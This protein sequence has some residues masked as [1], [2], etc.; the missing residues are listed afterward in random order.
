MTATLEQDAQASAQ[1]PVRGPERLR[2]WKQRFDPKADFIFTRRMTLGLPGLERVEP[3]DVVPR[4]TI[5]PNRLRIWWRARVIAIKDWAPRAPA[6]QPKKLPPLQARVE[7][8]GGGW[9]AVTV[10]GFDT[11]PQ[12]VRGRQAVD[13]L[14]A[15]LDAVEA[16]TGALFASD[17][18]GASTVE[19]DDEAQGAR[20]G[21][22]A[23]DQDAGRPGKEEQMKPGEERD[24]E[25]PSDDDE[26]EAAEGEA[27]DE[28]DEQ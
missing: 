12:R 20:T 3:G 8:C 18:Q 2:H 11:A 24:L 5:H 1:A 26:E 28:E 21:A 25:E 17:A 23:Q 14:L 19:P 15:E 9:F 22:D 4:G 7:A 6:V 10:Q 13:A 16:S 27:D